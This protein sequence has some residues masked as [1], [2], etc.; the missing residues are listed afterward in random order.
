VFSIGDQMH[1]AC[2]SVLGT[3]RPIQTEQ[4]AMGKNFTKTL[5]K[6]YRILMFHHGHG[7]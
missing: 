2:G 4:V 6:L 1:G 5:P 3:A 7:G